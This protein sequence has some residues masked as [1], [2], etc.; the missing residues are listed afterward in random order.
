[1]LYWLLFAFTTC[2]ETEV[3]PTKAITTFEERVQVE[4]VVINGF[5]SMGA[6][7]LKPRA[8]SYRG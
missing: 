3:E 2:S 1:M 5:E 6:I 4:N 8:R 7:S